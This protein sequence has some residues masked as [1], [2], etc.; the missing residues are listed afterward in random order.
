M[1]P[2]PKQHHRT[3]L[4]GFGAVLALL[5][6][7]LLAP[8]DFG[9]SDSPPSTKTESPA[10]V[11]DTALVLPAPETVAEEPIRPEIQSAIDP[12]TPPAR[13]TELITSLPLDLTEA[14][15]RVLIREV[16]TL[17]A[18]GTAEA[19]HSSHVHEICKILQRIPA[20][21]DLFAD[22][23]ATVAA[24][25][26]FTDVYRD[27]AFQHLRTLWRNSLDPLA[28][29]AAQPRNIAIEKTFRKLLAERPE[30][31]AKAIL[32]L[33]EFRH[34][35]GTPAV[36]DTEIGALVRQLLDTTASEE[37][38]HIP[39]RMTAV[40]VIAERNLPGSSDLL[41]S[42]AGSPQE[43]TLVRTSAIGALGHL[44]APEDK[45]FLA[46]LSSENPLIAEALRHALKQF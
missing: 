14:E 40:R 36:P 16:L 33:H 29:G 42:I 17:P 8:F 41:K 4:I 22:A 39:A 2:F 20:S 21:H 9:N 32:G 26:G 3:A 23:L 7:W 37:T 34:D 46:S 35:D 5:A 19:W 6:A 25:R 18:P 27:Y 13:R 11:L 44:A 30:T 31:S 10:T 45:T 15:W 43:H 38:T 24:H 12:K 28:P 1:K